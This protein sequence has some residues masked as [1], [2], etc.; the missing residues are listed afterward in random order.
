MLGEMYDERKACFDS[1]GT[2]YGPASSVPHARN[3]KRKNREVDAVTV[4]R[5]QD[6]CRNAILQMVR[7]DPCRTGTRSRSAR[8]TKNGPAVVQIGDVLATKSP[9][10]ERCNRG[11]PCEDWHLTK[12]QSGISRSNGL[13][14]SCVSVLFAIS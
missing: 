11:L 5:V 10:I 12:S 9:G 2:A 6:L 8:G 14:D 13:L 1:L 7:G 3:L 4:S